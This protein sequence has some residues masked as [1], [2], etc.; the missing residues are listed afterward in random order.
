MQTMPTPPAVPPAPHPRKRLALHWKILIGL[1]AGVVVGLILN[2]TWNAQTWNNLGVDN[3]PAFFEWKDR[4]V[5]LPEGVAT[6]ADLNTDDAT[7]KGKREWQLTRDQIARYGLDTVP[8]N[9]NAGFVAQ[10]ARFLRH[11]ATFIKTM[12]LR[13]LSFITV[14][15]VL[16]SLIVGASSLGDFK[17]LGRIGGRMA[18]FYITTTVLAILIGLTVALVVKPGQWL[19]DESTAHFR[20]QAAASGARETAD[21]KSLWQ[22]FTDLLPTNPFDSLARGDMLQ[23]V[24]MALLIGIAMATLPREK[25]QPVIAFF[26]GL[27]DTVI[28]LISW[29]MVLA[30]YAV[31]CFV[32]PVVAELG[33]DVLRSLAVY[34]LCVIGGLSIMGL[35]VYP[36]LAWTFGR[37]GMK[38][39]YKALAPAALLGFSSSSS[40]ATLPVVMECCEKRLGCS[41]E[42]VGFV[43]PVGAT[44]N[45]NGTGLYQAVA[46]V[47]IAQLFGLELSFEQMA[48]VVITATLSALGTAGVPGASIPLLAG[49]FATVGIPTEGIAVI[50]TI[51]RI[52]DMCRTVINVIGDAVVCAIVAAQEGELLSEDEVKRRRNTEPET[53]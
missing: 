33:L 38:R 2:G 32:V 28:R 21:P 17:K 30:P 27:S 22:F 1:L 10:T 48:T 20:A 45:Q 51:D 15:M 49:I 3:I 42:I 13:A 44:V 47:F 36:T 31:F 16:F 7:L 29:L 24:T 52:L 46:T 26:D 8:I 25:V 43:L 5:V 35:A 14:P 6:P 23:V 18:G 39:L 53:A 19:S 9:E 50:L 41:K 4:V 12:F 40:N 34:A 37:I 11:L